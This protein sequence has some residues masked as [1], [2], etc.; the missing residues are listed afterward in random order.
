MLP[1]L[2]SAGPNLN[3]TSFPS[4][5]FC[6]S[7]LP[8]KPLYHCKWCHHLYPQSP[9]HPK[10]GERCVVCNVS[11]L[12]LKKINDGENQVARVCF[13][14]LTRLWRQRLL[15]HKE[16]E[17]MPGIHY[18]YPVSFLERYSSCSFHVWELSWSI[19]ALLLNGQWK[20]LE[21]LSK[22]RWR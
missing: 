22:S 15:Y 18:V 10:D 20:L 12:G 14:W 2:D 5:A 13:W 21:L 1:P 3:I 19:F 6:L 4:S 16:W 7:P 17:M 9:A 11:G 8:Q